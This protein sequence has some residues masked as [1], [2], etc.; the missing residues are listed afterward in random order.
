MKVNILIRVNELLEKYAPQFE[1][2]RQVM[3]KAD[4]AYKDLPAEQRLIHS[5][6][7]RA[8]Y[9]ADFFR[10][11]VLKHLQDDPDI[12]IPP[13]GT[14]RLVIRDECQLTF[15]KLNEN[16]KPSYIPTWFYDDKP[17]DELQAM[18]EPTT[19]LVAGYRWRTTDQSHLYLVQPLENGVQWAVELSQPEKEASKET[20]EAKSHQPER[21]TRKV[22][23]KRQLNKEESV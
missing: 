15:K 17:D 9:I 13:Y 16:L 14:L 4:E 23:P 7:T 8:S 19:N 20:N 1:R 3:A 11:F 6:R 22:F 2:I 5:K 10:N 12:R 18:P 21:V